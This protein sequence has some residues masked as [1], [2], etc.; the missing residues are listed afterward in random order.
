MVYFSG[1]GG[2]VNSI[3]YFR[4]VVLFFYGGYEVRSIGYACTVLFTYLC[5]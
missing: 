2:V 5:T 1:E 3:S 4:F